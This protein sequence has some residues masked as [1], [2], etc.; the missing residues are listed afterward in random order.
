M[1]HWLSTFPMETSTYYTNPEEGLKTLRTLKT[2]ALPLS[3]RFVAKTMERMVAR[4]MNCY[5]ETNNILADEQVGFR[6]Y[7]STNLHVAMFSQHIK[8]ALDKGNL[9][10]IWFGRRISS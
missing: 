4:R 10:T 8:D 2:I 7:R 9:P 1:K 5:L 6:R 3:K